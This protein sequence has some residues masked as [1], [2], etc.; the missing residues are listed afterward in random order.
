M[1]AHSASI[2]M[3]AADEWAPYGSF[4]T[5]PLDIWQSICEQLSVEELRNLL[6]LN[7][8]FFP[9]VRKIY[10][11]R[12]HI[13]QRLAQLDAPQSGF[14][15]HDDSREWLAIDF[16]PSGKLCVLS[17]VSH[18]KSLVMLSSPSRSRLTELVECVPI[19][20]DPGDFQEFSDIC[21]SRKD[22]TIFLGWSDRIYCMNS[23]LR[24][25]S[26]VDIED[27]GH[28]A[29]DEYEDELY[30]T[31]INQVL[32]FS[33]SGR[34][35]RLP[36]RSFLCSAI[37]ISVGRNFVC[38]A[39]LGEDGDLVQLLSKSTGSVMRYHAF[40]LPEAPKWNIM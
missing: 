15:N 21:L 25:L 16:L 11:S 5:L 9:L 6:V 13:V 4:G 37:A 20:V 32:V 19:P 23:D 12:R 24:A 35:N 31:T 22:G 14:T 17:Y 3:A 39:V 26:H 8:S 30:V 36:L 29:H 18:T 34:S 2:L 40:G 1:L 10:D 7:H 27:L 28:I 38:C 33:A